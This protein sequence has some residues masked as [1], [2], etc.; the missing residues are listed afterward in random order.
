MKVEKDN[1]IFLLVFAAISFEA[2]RVRDLKLNLEKRINEVEE[3]CWNLAKERGNSNKRID[4]I[5]MRNDSLCSLY[6]H[7]NK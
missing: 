4:I 5:E 3:I 6:L 2:Y 1:V 7:S